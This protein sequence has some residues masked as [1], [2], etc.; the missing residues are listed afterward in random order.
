MTS[1]IV[2]AMNSKA[3]NNPVQKSPIQEKH[4]IFGTQIDGTFEGMEEF[5]VGMG[6]F[7]GAE[8]R[9]WGQSGVVHTA[10]GYS[11]GHTENST[12]G[13]A[14]DVETGRA[15]CVRVVYDPK[16]TDFQSLLKVF[17]ESHDPTQ[18]NRQGNDVGTQYRSALYLETDEQYQIAKKSR[19]TY[20][21]ALTQAGK[22]HIS[23]DLR[24]GPAPKFFYAEDFHQQYLDK[25][26]G[27]SCSLKG[28]GVQCARG[29]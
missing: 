2:S 4:S 20:K 11:G 14:S 29:E 9:Y 12:N 16:K 23:T 6:C 5:Q 17:W 19:D 28:T 10:V 24:E 27:G 3:I 8:Q 26:S 25:N 22:G 21:E 13:E 1:K 15:E 18:Q 7:W